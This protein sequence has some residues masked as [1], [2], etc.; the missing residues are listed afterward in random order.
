MIASPY[1]RNTIF[2]KCSNGSR[3]ENL[4]VFEQKSAMSSQSDRKGKSNEM[5]RC[6]YC[7]FVNSTESL[8]H[9]EVDEIKQK[10]QIDMHNVWKHLFPFIVAMEKVSDGKKINV[11]LTQNISRTIRPTVRPYMLRRFTHENINGQQCVC[12]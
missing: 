12:Q 6:L 9:R 2:H 8:Q 5:V 1:E 3:K 11:N 10:T 4:F 7:F